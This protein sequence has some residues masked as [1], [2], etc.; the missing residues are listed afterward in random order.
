MNIPMEERMPDDVINGFR[1]LLFRI[2]K[3]SNKE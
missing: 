3:I 2:P 1:S